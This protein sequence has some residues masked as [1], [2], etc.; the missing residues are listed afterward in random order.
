ML[1]GYHPLEATD[2]TVASFLASH[3]GYNYARAL[4]ARV[5]LQ[6]VMSAIHGLEDEYRAGREV[7]NDAGLLYYLA[8]GYTRMRG[9]GAMRRVR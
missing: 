3:V 8:T 6:K 5:G 1:E 7:R 2:D 4:I 9:R